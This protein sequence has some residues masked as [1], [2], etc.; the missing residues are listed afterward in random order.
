MF[1]TYFSMVGVY[2]AGSVACFGY[3]H[4]WKS[5]S[6]AKKYQVGFL[7]SDFAFNLSSLFVITPMTIEVNNYLCCHKKIC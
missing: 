7:L 4:P 6:T 1:P 3:T 2:C 5:S